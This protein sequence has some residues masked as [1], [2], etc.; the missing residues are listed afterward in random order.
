[1]EYPLYKSSYSVSLFAKN[2][3]FILNY[4]IGMLISQSTLTCILFKAS[5][6]NR[7][8]L[9]ENL[10]YDVLFF[11]NSYSSNFTIY[12]HFHQILTRN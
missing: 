4:H 8:A 10:E 7:I 12:I 1:M 3:L 5:N 11:N 2:K 6:C 9:Q